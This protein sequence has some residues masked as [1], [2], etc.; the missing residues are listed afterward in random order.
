MSQKIFFVDEEGVQ[1]W[2]V[3]EDGMILDEDQEVTDWF[4]RTCNGGTVVHIYQGDHTERGDRDEDV[5]LEDIFDYFTMERGRAEAWFARMTEKAERV[6]RVN[7]LLR[8]HGLDCATIEKKREALLRE[9]G[10]LD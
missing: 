9:H 10:L 6:A 7:A 5:E 2:T 8:E 1:E 3:R 4:L